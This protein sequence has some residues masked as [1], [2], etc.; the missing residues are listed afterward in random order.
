MPKHLSS[1]SNAAEN[2]PESTPPPIPPHQQAIAFTVLCGNDNFNAWFYQD[3][4]ANRGRGVLGL[5]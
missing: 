4:A 2:A 3:L 5:L 1:L